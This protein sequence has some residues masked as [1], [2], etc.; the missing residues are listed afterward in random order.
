MTTKVNH[1]DVEFALRLL[2]HPE[3]EEEKIYR[4]WIQEEEHQ[5]LL[6]ELRS[7]R[8]AGLI[9]FDDE[10]VDVGRMWQQFERTTINSRRLK[11]YRWVASVAALL[12]IGIG[13]W[14][15][16][17]SPVN[18]KQELGLQV[19]YDLGKG[20]TLVTD[21]VAVPEMPEMDQIPGVRTFK[22]DSLSGIRYSEVALLAGADTKYHVLRVPR[23][24]DY[25]VILEDSTCVWVN[26]ESELRYPAKFSGEERVVELVGEAYFKVHPDSRHPFKV[27]TAMVETRVLGTEFNV[28]AYADQQLN[29]TLVEG[30]IGVKMQQGEVQEMILKPGENASLRA[31][32]LEVEGVDVLK[33]I[34]WKNGYFY[35]DDAR[36]EDILNEL[37]RWYDF[38]VTYQSEEVK[39]LRFKFWAGRY[40]SFERMLMR[41]NETGKI[42]LLVVGRQVKVAIPE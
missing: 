1:D 31:G 29:V 13:I 7:F 27:K 26:A 24:A 40:E 41:L 6:K 17:V 12:I 34:S 16:V 36:L 28:Q 35:Y 37:G 18:R 33:F 38:K 20:V 19:E 42:S 23:G 2:N 39:D 9:V 10:G 11:L 3:L 21:A 30:S 32:E 15:L 4:E 14:G 22:Q 5:V 8:E 25:M